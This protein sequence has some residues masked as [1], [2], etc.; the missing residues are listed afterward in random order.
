MTIMSQKIKQDR[1]VLDRGL[2][3]WPQMVVWGESVSVDQAKEIIR[4]TDTFFGCPGLYKGNNHAYNE[5]LMDRLNIPSTDDYSSKLTPEVRQKMWAD[6][7]KWIEEWGY[8]NTQYVHNDW[9][10]CAYIFGPHGW[11]HPDGTIQFS[12]IS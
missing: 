10:S 8:I 4:R 6:Q 7:E 1:T 5:W 11:C 12:D 9:I 2:S 3:K